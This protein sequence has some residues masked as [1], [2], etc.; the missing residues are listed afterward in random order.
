MKDF[1][2]SLFLLW[3][4]ILLSILTES[5]HIDKVKNNEKKQVGLPVVS[6]CIFFYGDAYIVDYDDYHYKGEAT[7]EM[8]R[9]D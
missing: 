2:A 6:F 3:V 9:K 8:K 4:V 7:R 5:Q 1:G